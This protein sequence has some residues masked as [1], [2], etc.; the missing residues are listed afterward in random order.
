MPLFT[1]RNTLKPDSR[2]RIGALQIGEHESPAEDWVTDPML[3]VVLK[4]PYGGPGNEDVVVPMG[5][6]IAVDEPVQVYTGKLKTRLTI[7]NGTN[8]VIGCAPY[9]FVKDMSNNDRFGGNKPAIIT[10][11]YIRLPYIPISGDSNLCPWGHVTGDNITVGDFLKPTV[12]GQFT[13]WD[14]AVDSH[15]QV[16]GQVLA[17]DF[18]QEMFGFLKMAMWAE[19]MKYD[20]EAYQNFY[21]IVY[22][23]DQNGNG[24]IGGT[25]Y[26][27]GDF[28]TNFRDL[29]KGP[30]DMAAQGYLGDYQTLWTGVPGLT[31]GAGRALTRFTGKAVATI[32]AAV[33][34]GNTIIMHVKD[35]LGVNMGANLTDI[36][37]GSD[38]SRVFVLKVGGVV[39]TQGLGNGQYQ[40]NYKT[41]QIT[42]Y[43]KA[44]DAGKNVTAD[45]CVKFYGTTSY[46]DFRGAIGSFNVLLKM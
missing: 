38:P 39:A 5:R 26:N 14:E 36:Y 23:E 4:N 37:A 13:K 19:S 33:A 6:L 35:D 41:G 22:G 42:Y 3:P 20:D 9:N 46:I 7:A 8:A 44:T 40:I 17:K 10:D 11:K 28:N 15:K 29:G 16:V 18:N 24:L 25:G 30:I 43:A 27:G 21:K 31:D 2:S 32:G 1:G 34:D 45:Y 12:N